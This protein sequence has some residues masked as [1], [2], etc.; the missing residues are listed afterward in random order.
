MQDTDEKRSETYLRRFAELKAER[1]NT[2][3]VGTLWNFAFS[4]AEQERWEEAFVLF[5]QALAECGA[6]P[7]RGENHKTFGLVYGHSGDYQS[8]EL[9][10]QKAAELMPDDTEVREALAIVEVWPREIGGGF[11]TALRGK[12]PLAAGLPPD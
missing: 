10:L 2:D 11:R 6:C 7:A 9:Q 1:Q 5:R 3:R 12:S 8:T 4:E